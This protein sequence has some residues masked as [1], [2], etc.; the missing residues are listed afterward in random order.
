MPNPYQNPAKATHSAVHAVA[1]TPN[2]STTF[3]ATRGVYVGGAGDLTVTMASG[4]IVTFTAI[5]TSV[6]HPISVTQIR[7]TG[8][9][10]TNI[11]ILY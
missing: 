7:N 2:D 11:V 4:E 1:A 8:T 3:D 9:D 10:A 6:I 5:A